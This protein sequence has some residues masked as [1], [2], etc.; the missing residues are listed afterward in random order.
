MIA[1]IL[2]G[3]QGSR[4]WPLSRRDK[5]KQFQALMS[6]K[7]MLV[8]AYDRLR[9]RM[10]TDDIFVSVV[11]EFVSHVHALL[12]DIPFDHYLV[13]PARRDS[14]PAM[15]FAAQQ[16]VNRGRGDEVFVFVPTDHAIDDTDRFLQALS[17]GEQLVQDTGKLLD[18]SVMPEFASTSLG[19]TRIGKQQVKHQGIEVYTFLEHKEKPDKETAELYVASG[20][21]LWHANYYMWKPSRLLEAYQ[22]H[23]PDI[24]AVVSVWQ[25][26]E[27]DRQAFQMLR[28]I[29]IDKAVTEFLAPDDVLIIKGDF[30]WSDVGA[31]NVLSERQSDRADERGNVLR[32]K[33]LTVDSDRCYIYG[34]ADK[35]IAAFGISDL[36]IIDTEDA[37]LVC[38]KD[39]APEMKLLIEEMKKAK[40]DDYL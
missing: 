8:D 10:E 39:R 35:I 23:A 13:E 7:A 9:L 11:P 38:P 17:V 16:L 40:L 20:E 34:Q 12:P 1:V 37:L 25:D 33:A 14:G 4:L 3:G 5:P 29:S 21:Y 31:F 22:R 6:E 27:G 26:T 30:G 18:I 28:P 19:Y 24:Y 15:A 36:V 2:A 32:G